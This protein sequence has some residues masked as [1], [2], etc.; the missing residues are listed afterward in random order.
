[1]RNIGFLG[2]MKV[3]GKSFESRP[4]GLIFLCSYINMYMLVSGQFSPITQVFKA[5]QPSWQLRIPLTGMLECPRGRAW[6][7]AA[8]SSFGSPFGWVDRELSGSRMSFVAVVG[9]AGGFF[10]AQ[11]CGHCPGCW[12]MF[13]VYSCWLVSMPTMTSLLNLFFKWMLHHVTLSTSS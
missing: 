3:W 7:C 5:I 11:L 9:N 8:P 10:W 1:M 2:D 4:A 13:K 6:W 12:R